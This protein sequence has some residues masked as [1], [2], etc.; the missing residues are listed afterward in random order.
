[1][2]DIVDARGCAVSGAT[3]AAVD[4]L[5][6]ALA[7]LLAWRSGAEAHAAVALEAAPRLVMAHAPR[8]GGT[9][10]RAQL[11]FDRDTVLLMVPG[12]ERPTVYRIYAD[13]ACT[14]LLYVGASTLPRKRLLDHVR[15]KPAGVVVQLEF[16]RN[17]TAMARAEREAIANENP[18]MD[19]G[20]ARRHGTWKAQLR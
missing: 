14:R 3:P 12:G 17:T 13:H 19:C 4:L 11:G 2:S 18:E 7:A 20:T 15:S 6:R 8:A 5:E 10:V 9:G 1:M 16:F